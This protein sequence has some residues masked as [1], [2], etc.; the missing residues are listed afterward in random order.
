M[1]AGRYEFGS[2]KNLHAWRIAN[3]R[4]ELI[5]LAVSA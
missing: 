2:S 1:L 3:R 5:E 4:A